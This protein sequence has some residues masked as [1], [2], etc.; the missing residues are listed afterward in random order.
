MND[1]E[2]A[3]KCEGEGGDE[4]QGTR[5]WG[6]RSNALHVDEVGVVEVPVGLVCEGQQLAHVM[7]A[8]MHVC[9]GP[10]VSD[11]IRLKARVPLMPGDVSEGVNAW[12][13]WTG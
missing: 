3:E 4:M 1:R 6:T 9:A 13:G 5:C 2:E 8:R 7:G 12:V 10:Q 11:L